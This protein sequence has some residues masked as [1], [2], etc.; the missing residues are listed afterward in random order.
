MISRDNSLVKELHDTGEGLLRAYATILFSN[1][2][3]IG[4]LFVA[5]SFWYP[6][7]GLA[8]LIGAIVGTVTARLLSFPN[9]SQGLHIYNSLLVGLALGIVY[10][11][12]NYLIVLIIMGAVLAVILTV[13]LT[14]VLWRLEHLPVLSL[15]FVMV[16]FTCFF[17]AQAYGNLSIYLYPSTPI[18]PFFGGFIDNFLVALGSAFFI[19]HPIAGLMFFVGL[20]FTSRYLALL[21]IAGYFVGYSL[22][23]W[24]TG[25]IHPVMGQWG[26]FNFILT[27]IAVGGIFTIPSWQ[28]FLLAMVAAALS[29]VVAMA[30]QGVLQIY[31]LPV[32]AIPFLLTT[33]T[34]LAAMRKRQTTAP[35]HLL[36]E[37]P[38]L[39]ECSYEEARLAK[40]RGAE[41]DSV[42]LAAPFFGSWDI[43]Q[44][45]NGPHTHKAPWQHALD[46]IITKRGCSFRNNGASLNDYYCYDLPV[47]S[48]CYGTVVRYQ[49][50]LLDNPPGE[51]DGKNNW[52]NF[53]LIYLDSGLYV[54]LA[55]LREQSVTVVEGERVVPGH[56][57]AR[58]GNT[59]RSPQPHLHVHVQTTAVL[60]SPTQSF[61]LVGVTVQS[62]NESTAGFYLASRPDEGDH[63][64]VLKSD[65]LLQHALHMP[66]GLQLRYRYCLD[67]I[68]WTSQTLTVSMDLEGHF[69]LTSGSGA[70]TRFMEEGG[71]LYF[72][73]RQG[74][75]DT[76]LDTWL[77][78]LGLSPLADA[79][80]EWQDR[81]S[82]R[83]LPLNYY[84]SFLRSFIRPLGG[85]LN[86]RYQ[87]VKKGNIW[88]QNGVH[89]LS[90]LPGLSVKSETEVHIVPDRGCTQLSLKTNELRVEAVLEEILT[91]EDQGIPQTEINLIS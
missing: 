18:E 59:G 39:P 57:L 45:F 5:A 7:A 66:L 13:A 33:L 12:D 1:N 56:P 64:S 77:L 16:A 80:I 49:D 42:P 44:G 67:D 31:S 35:P 74:S 9:I 75:K 6:N 51:V 62:E 82:D 34:I 24:L 76:L 70:S 32:L 46:F 10:R 61:H 54:L 79:T 20:L 14:D 43:Y 36:L 48:P 50:N 11:L 86:S 23:T 37:A 91:L 68:H 40:S 84:H 15:P 28:S 3:L 69:L 27:A 4:V 60:G 71:V 41:P 73:H 87:R 25:S 81:P 26:G 89:Q 65:G 29:S 63:V 88:H 8:G 78:A 85:G 38:S 90:L 19:P 2:W 55:H 47:L 22:L 72:Y 21:A 52:G 53:V 83:L 58:C 30:V 17:A